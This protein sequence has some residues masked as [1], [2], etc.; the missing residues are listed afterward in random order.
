MGTIMI[1]QKTAEWI[2]RRLPDLTEAPADRWKARREEAWTPPSEECV[3]LRIGQREGT[4][5]GR[6]MAKNWRAEGRIYCQVHGP[7]SSEA[8]GN[9]DGFV[10]CEAVYRVGGSEK[11]EQFSASRAHTL[12]RFRGRTTARSCVPAGRYR[13][14]QESGN[15]TLTFWTPEWEP[16]R[17]VFFR[18]QEDGLEG[19]IAWWPST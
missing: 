2:Q 10:F 7:A 12:W 13:I 14:Q 8:D 17:T 1:G 11:F 15:V 18:Y 5:M 4:I 6:V 19:S 16:A 9:G 3:P